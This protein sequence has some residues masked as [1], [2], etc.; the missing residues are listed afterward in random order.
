V[1]PFNLTSKE[2]G[3]SY[4]P[5]RDVD[6]E[7]RDRE[8]ILEEAEDEYEMLERDVAGPSGSR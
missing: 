1:F 6:R 7:D 4:A 3:E 8:D 5:L 2:D